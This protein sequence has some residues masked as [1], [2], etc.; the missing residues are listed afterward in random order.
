MND[1]MKVADL[2]AAL[3]EASVIKEARVEALEE[4]IKWWKKK[5]AAEQ[6][7]HNID[8]ARLENLRTEDTRKEQVIKNLQDEMRYWMKTAEERL[9]LVTSDKESQELISD[10]QAEKD[11]V[12]EANRKYQ[13]QLETALEE[14]EHLKEQLVISDF[15]ATKAKAEAAKYKDAYMHTCDEHVL[16]EEI[17]RLK[18]FKNALL[19]DMED[20]ENERNLLR[21][22]MGEKNAEIT[23]LKTNLRHAQQN[24]TD[25][26]KA[27]IMAKAA[28]D[29]RQK[30]VRETRQKMGELEEQLRNAVEDRNY[31]RGLA[32]ENGEQIEMLKSSELDDVAYWKNLADTSHEQAK[33]YATKLGKIHQIVVEE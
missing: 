33:N 9:K 3:R 19:K 11:R 23:Q 24:F 32:I 20:V 22:A 14:I 31:W 6:D 4:D 1:E 10:L 17:D 7:E 16:H 21:D 28:N 29:S 18:E 5:F 8:K 30:E 27:R 12:W 15:G 2:I 25:A 13:D 26:E